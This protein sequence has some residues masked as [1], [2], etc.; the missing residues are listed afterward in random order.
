M[1]KKSH[2]TGKTEYIYA[3]VRES[4]RFADEVI[5]YPSYY[6]TEDC[7]GYLK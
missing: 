6:L 1:E 3:R 7:I 4:A 5:S 2:F